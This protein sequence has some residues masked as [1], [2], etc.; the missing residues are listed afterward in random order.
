M[1]LLHSHDHAHGAH[2]DHDTH[3]A[4]DGQ[5][6]GFDD[7]RAYLVGIVLNL[8]FV[9]VE[10][11]YGLLAHSMALLADA[12]HN[13]SDVLG[14][15]V[16]GGASLLARR[17]PSERRTYGFKR[18][19]I[20][21]A[22]GNGLLLVVA[23]GAIAWESIGRLHQPGPIQGGLVATVAAVGVVVNG[24]SALLL[25]KGRKRDVNVQAAFVHLAADG[26]V[27]AG[28]VVTGIVIAFTGY[29][30]LDPVVSL[31]LSVVI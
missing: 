1:G 2:D 12:G 4:H 26:V 24:V 10:V 16:A 22:L 13:L 5:E 27:A 23:T 18:A 28:V 17:K 25:M 8:V 9:V 29:S 7:R 20:L 14:L 6:G 21:A 3:G 31:V 15:L 19:T 30:V 11:F